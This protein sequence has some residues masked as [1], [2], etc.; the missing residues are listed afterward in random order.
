MITL[1]TECYL[2]LSGF[3]GGF[4]GLT[5]CS[6]SVEM[7][8]TI[9][10]SII[11]RNQLTVPALPITQ[12]LI[13]YKHA[14]NPNPTTKNINVY[15]HTMN[16]EPDDSIVYIFHSPFLLRVFLGAR[17]LA[18]PVEPWARRGNYIWRQH[19]LWHSG[20]HYLIRRGTVLISSTLWVRT[21]VWTTE[22]RRQC[23]LNA[24][25]I[26]NECPTKLLGKEQNRSMPMCHERHCWYGDMI[27]FEGDT[28]IFIDREQ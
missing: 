8:I 2:I 26:S 1:S 27:T 14:M 28:E 23:R 21:C 10:I 6:R 7:N 15:K 9:I 22:R 20:G 13:M 16:P 18:V 17:T 4:W 19:F 24:N 3:E 11:L 12:D 5:R 25:A